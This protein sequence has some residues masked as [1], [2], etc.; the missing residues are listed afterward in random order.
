M[1][2]QSEVFVTSSSWRKLATFG[3]VASEKVG[4]IFD[5]VKLQKQKLID[6]GFEDVHDIAYKVRLGVN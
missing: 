6:V 2:R 1:P 5:I 3:N 4:R